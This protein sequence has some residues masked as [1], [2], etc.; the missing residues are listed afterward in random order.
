VPFMPF[1]RSSRCS[2][3]NLAQQRPLGLPKRKRRTPQE[4]TWQ[5]NEV[6]ELNAVSKT[7]NA[8]LQQNPAS[9]DPQNSSFREATDDAT[10]RVKP[11]IV[12]GIIWP[13]RTTH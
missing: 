13:S 4:P 6:A 2:R 5:N 7:W 11:R 3:R 12:L 8:K 1:M 10:L 9:A